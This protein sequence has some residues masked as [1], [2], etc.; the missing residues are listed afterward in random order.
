[1]KRIFFIALIGI[2]FSSAFAGPTITVKVEIGKKKINGQPVTGCPQFGFCRISIENIGAG[3]ENMSKG[4]LQV[5]D[6]A[7][8]VTIG[9]QEADILRYQ[10]D[11]INYFQKK[12]SVTFD[13]DF[14]FPEDINNA[15][16]ASKPLVIKAGTYPLSYKD[17]IYYITFT[18]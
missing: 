15:A 7:K 5:S 9:I 3:T 2:L 13:E 16:K 6:D 18:L 11:K 10:P 12:T 14:V 4:T 8:S 1:M 17:G